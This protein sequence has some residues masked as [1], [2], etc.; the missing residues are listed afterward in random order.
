MT[1]IDKAVL[2]AGC[3]ILLAVLPCFGAEAGALVQPF[4]VGE[5]EVWAI[6]DSTG[7]RTLDVFKDADPAA[8][9]KY[10]P[11]GKAPTAI[12][13]FAIR[14][15]GKTILMDTGLGNPSGD[16]ASRL[17][18]GLAQAGLDPAAID[19]VLITHM[20][21]DHIGGLIWNGEKAFPNAEV[22][23]GKTELDYWL[24]DNALKESPGRKANFELARKV[25]ALYGDR[26]GT[27]LFDQSV[28]PGIVS[29]PAIGHTPGHTAFLL[30][31]GD[32]KLLCV[33]DLLHAA[34]LQFPRPD[35]NSSYDMIPELAAAARAALLEYAA[36]ENIPI[37]GMHLPFAG[38]GRVEK[39]AEGGYKYVPAF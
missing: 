37:A 4:R 13:T 17:M 11:T 7:E 9:A 32:E 27:F 34:D 16:R 2:L 6:A 1:F 21:G 22:L 18:A 36:T 33:G 23:I 15:G 28:A 8:V 31:S 12:M 10:M 19:A 35:I 29:K 5:A 14:N 24:D 25:V 38:V 3:A 39:A 20:H 30:Q 26:V